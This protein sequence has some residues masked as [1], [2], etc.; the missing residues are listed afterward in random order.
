MC[1]G[2][3]WTEVILNLLVD[4]E[5]SLHNFQL[6]TS[7]V[8]AKS[9]FSEMPLQNTSENGI[10]RGLIEIGKGNDVEVSLESRGNE[11]LATTWRSHRCNDHCVNYGPVGMLIVLAIIPAITVHKLP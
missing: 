5:S 6:K 7:N 2:W 11:G 3:C 10:K 9:S 1:L 4:L 8:G